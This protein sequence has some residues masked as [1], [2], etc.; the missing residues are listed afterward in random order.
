[1]PCYIYATGQ[2]RIIVDGGFFRGADILKGIASGA[3]CVAMGRFV[4]IGLAAVRCV[5]NYS[6]TSTNAFFHARFVFEHIS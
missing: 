5:C 3:D 1:M 2:N 4:A 6:T